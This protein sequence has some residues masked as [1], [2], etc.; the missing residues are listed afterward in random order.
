VAS[1]AVSGRRATLTRLQAARN[2]EAPARGR[3]T[4]KALRKLDFILL[5]LA[6]PGTHTNRAACTRQGRGAYAAAVLPHYLLDAL[7]G[8][9]PETAPLVGGAEDAPVEEGCYIAVRH[10]E[11][12]SQVGYAIELRYLRYFRYFRCPRRSLVVCAPLAPRPL[13][14]CQARVSGT[15]RMT[16][17]QGMSSRISRGISEFLTRRYST[18]L[19]WRRRS[20]RRKVWMY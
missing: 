11:G 13:C 18:G 16:T 19:L 8:E 12:G 15:S 2:I 4:S 10:L 20:S 7:V 17:C 9:E 3:T 5:A 1:T 6:I 14:C